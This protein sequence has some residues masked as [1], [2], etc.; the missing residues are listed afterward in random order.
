MAF[1]DTR[2][3]VDV[4]RGAL[5]GPGFKTTV[6]PLGSG[7]EQRNI[8]WARTRAEF[9]IGYGLMDQDS[10]ILE[11]TIDSLLAFFYTR[12]GKAHTF[13][14]KDWSDFKIGD[15]QNPTT[16]NQSVATG[17]TSIT[18]TASTISFTATDT[19]SDSGNDL[20]KFLAADYIEISG[21][22]SNDG[23]FLI[24]TTSAGTITVPSGIVNEGA[25]ASV[26]I[27]LLRETDSIFK[28]YS[29]GGIN[30]DR[31]ITHLVSGRVIVL[32]DN[33][34]QTENT[35]YTV[36]LTTG[37]ITWLAGFWPAV[38]VDIQVALEFDI[39]MRFD[40]DKLKLNLLMFRRGSWQNIPLVEEKQ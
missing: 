29:D 19:I 22:A 13:R 24:S 4:E 25:G 31:P 18:L 12:E 6:T 8:D 36:N 2:L 7:K 21:S 9:D 28:R 5:G 32:K 11:A 40:T 16:D 26:T 38:G 23:T 17:G 35:H 33:V 37:I 1:H 34:V 39:P 27:T 10:V 30:Y 20:E 15:W 3:P 14:F